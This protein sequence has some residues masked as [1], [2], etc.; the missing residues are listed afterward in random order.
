MALQDVGIALSILNIKLTAIENNFYTIQLFDLGPVSVIP[1]IF[2]VMSKIHIS[3]YFEASGIHY[4]HPLN[5]LSQVVG[6][7]T[8]GTLILTQIHAIIIHI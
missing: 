3:F 8:K 4:S 7:R 6:C 2:N 5:A 1:N